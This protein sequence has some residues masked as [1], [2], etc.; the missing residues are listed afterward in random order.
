MADNQEMVAAV[1]GVLDSLLRGDLDEA[2][3]SLK[4]IIEGN[5]DKECL[6]ILLH[7]KHLIDQFREGISFIN[8]ISDG[9]LDYPAPHHFYLYSHY[10]QLQSNLRYLT[11][12]TQQIAKGDYE[13]SV[14]FMGDFSVSFNQL[15]EGLK[16]KKR[17]Q[18]QLVELSASRDK[19]FSIISHDL[20]SSFN[21]ILG[22]SELLEQDYGELDDRERKEYVYNIR[23]SARNAF[24]LLE[25]LLEWSRVQTGNIAFIPE[26]L[27]ISRLVLENF[28]LLKPLAQ[29]KNIHLFSR[30]SIDLMARGDLNSVLTILRNLISNA[31]KFTP[32]GGKVTVEAEKNGRMVFI[33]VRDTG[34]GIS[35]AN[36][37]KL[38]VTGESFKTAGTD[39]EK[40]T[41][42]GLIL[43][44]EFAEKNGGSIKVTSEEGKGSCFTFTLPGIS[45]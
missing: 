14:N 9:D 4:K 19:F 1:T 18:D 40:G 32:A 17:F 39:N 37:A 22:F 26:D 36:I 42:L 23:E 5:P 44:K 15:I 16:E 2:E 7:L 20:K 45:L 38:F 11:W 31:I 13:Q 24:K 30:V 21:A 33:S 12:Q 35:A 27:S 29:K 34:V 43:C 6:P 41:G 28:L 8:A 25:N 3:S 10:K